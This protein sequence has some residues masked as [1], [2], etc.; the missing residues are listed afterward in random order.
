MRSKFMRAGALSGLVMAAF[1]TMPIPAAATSTLAINVPQ[2]DGNC[3]YI[4]AP[5]NRTV[6]LTW[7]DYAGGLKESASIPTGSDDP[8][9]CSTSNIIEVGDKL[10]V[11]MGSKSHKLTI[12]S[13]TGRINRVTDVIK[14]TGPAGAHLT[15]YCGASPFGGFEP[16]QWSK[17]V[18]VSSAGTWKVQ[19]PLDLVGGWT[20]DV[21][22]HNSFGDVA[23]FDVTAPWFQ[24]FIGQ[25][26]FSGVAQPLS[27]ATVDLDDSSLEFKGSGSG[28]AAPRTGWFTGQLRDAQGDLVTVAAGDHVGSDVAAGASFVVPMIVA[29][30]TA[31]DD[32]VWGSCELT[33]TYEGVWVELYRDGHLR[34]VALE[35][36]TDGT[37]DFDFQETFPDRANV[38]VGDK[39]FV[40]CIQGEGD[41]AIKVIFAQ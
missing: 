2:I 12:P 26:R 30:A 15:I 20:M 29:N 14:G 1:L 34:G 31:A 8:L 16:C 4:K 21:T 36:F 7:K 5:A 40:K 25:A 37:F 27:T 10:K 22:W 39:L 35:G 41:Y 9:Y 19:T 18:T 38:M 23:S 3:L 28:D 11:V 24:V 17:N 33:P 32:H 6:T 13:L